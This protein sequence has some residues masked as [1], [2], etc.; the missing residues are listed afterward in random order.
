VIAHR[1]STIKG[2]DMIYVL[3]QGVVSEFGTHEALM[4]NCGEYYA[5]NA[6][7]VG[8]PEGHVRACLPPSLAVVATRVALRLAP[9]T[10][11]H[12]ALGWASAASVWCGTGRSRR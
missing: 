9:A 4:G 1:L 7:Q 6:A 2:S 12:P 10:T 8:S 5:L 3:K 11:T